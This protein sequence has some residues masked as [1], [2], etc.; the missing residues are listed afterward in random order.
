MSSHDRAISAIGWGKRNEPHRGAALAVT[1][2]VGL[3]EPR[4]TL[5]LAAPLFAVFL[6]AVAPL[7]LAQNSEP[8]TSLQ[9]APPLASPQELWQAWGLDLA[10]L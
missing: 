6:V 8:P 4:L 1:K 3:A 10:G 2:T 7:A 5:Q 9:T